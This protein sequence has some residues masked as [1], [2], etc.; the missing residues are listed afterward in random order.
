[1]TQERQAVLDGIAAP[2]SRRLDETRTLIAIGDPG[3]ER[4]VLQLLAEDVYDGPALRLVR[5]CLDADDLLGSVPS[6]EVDAAIVSADLHGFGVDALHALARVRLPLLLWGI[7]TTTA[8]AIDTAGVTILPRDVDIAE[9]RDAI[10]DLATTGGRLRRSARQAA[11]PA[12][13]LERALLPG[14]AAAASDARR[15]ERGGTILALVGAP[16]GQGVS[17][18]AA[19][20]TAALSAKGPAALVDLNLERPSQAL[21]LDLNP[22]RNL[23]MVLH[24]AGTRQDAN[25]RARL[26][27]SELQPLDASLPRAVALAGAPSGGLAANVNA[28]GVR[29]LLCQLASHEQFVVADVGCTVDGATPV[30]AAHRAAL[31][32]ADRVFVVSRS[33]IIG[34]RRAAQLLEV[35]RGVLDK[36]ERRLAVLLNQHHAR[37]DHDAV[38]VARALR[39]P[40]AAVIPNDPRGVHT[41]L[42]AQRPLVA[43]GGTGRG[44]AARALVDLARELHDAERVHAPRSASRSIRVGLNWPRLLG[45]LQGR[46][47]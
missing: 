10:R 16:G 13:E 27:E 23:S 3:R 42:A 5:R 8:E 45:P 33:D 41:A 18:L 38:D 35:L 40:V 21:A 44:S 46:R 7:N 6:G 15:A 24:E 34:L 17:V 22:A 37:H 31:E 30:A 20:L 25:A 47:P 29:D 36:P 12:A 11:M 39:T 1:V 2:P 9:L 32:A 43:F 28:D 26:L 14:H 4:A 19:G